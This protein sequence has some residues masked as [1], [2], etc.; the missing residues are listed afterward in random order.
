MSNS[1]LNNEEVEALLSAI[2][3]GQVLVGQKIE[4]KRE[5]KVQHYDFRRP[6]R[7]PREQKRRLQKISEEVAKSVGVTL[8][9]YLRTSVVVEL[10]AIEEFSYEVFI[11]SFT[12]VICANV[13]NLKPLS[14]LGCLTIDVGFCLAIV[15]RGLGGPGKIPQKVRPLTMIEESVVGVVLSNIMEDIKMCW[16]KLAKLEWSL[17]KMEMDIKSLQLV[18]IT[19]LMISINF[20]ISGDLGN[21]T[22]ILCMPVASLEMLMIKAKLEKVDRQKEIAI[23]ENVINEVELNAT[24]VFGSTQLSLNEL[25]N[26]RAGDVVKLDNKI[27]EDLCLTIAGKTKHYGKPGVV[28]KKVAFQVS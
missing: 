23:I 20:A 9:R 12:D 27:T 3:G 1:I 7:F 21:G 15:D 17:E 22:I 6:D 19:E 18:P 13:V 10:I 28:G 11:N 4:P 2:E 26:L 5:K 16:S 25:M 8:S 24:V 14:G